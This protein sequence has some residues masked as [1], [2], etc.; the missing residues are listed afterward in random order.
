[1]LP[2]KIGVGALLISAF[3]VAPKDRVVELTLPAG[4]HL[5]GTLV[6]TISTETTPV[7]SRVTLRTDETTVVGNAKLPAGMLVKG[8]VTEARRGGRVKTPAQVSFRF[9]S[10]TIEGREYPITTEPWSVKG[11]S[12]TKNSLKKVIG[13]TVI[14]GV[15][16]AVAGETK[17]GLVLGALIGTGAAVATK[18]GNITLPAGQRV[19]VSLAEPVTV[20]VRYANLYPDQH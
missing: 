10:L 14:G 7:G 13:G 1:M 8:E 5:S 19:E 2:Y 9:T 16:G 3:T 20:Q 18:G 15:V 12:E 11:K 4:T 17:E 6:Q